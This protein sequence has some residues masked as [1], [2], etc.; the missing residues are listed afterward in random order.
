MNKMK[1][2]SAIKLLCC[3][4]KCSKYLYY[5][6]KMLCVSFVVLALIFGVSVLTNGKCNIKA[7][8]GLF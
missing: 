3:I 7:L 8:K 5:A 1:Y 6:K 2:A 4:G